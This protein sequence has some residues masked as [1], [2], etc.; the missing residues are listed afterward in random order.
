[1]KNKKILL[2]VI[3]MVAVISSFVYLAG[4][5]QAVEK[6]KSIFRPALVGTIATLDVGEKVSFVTRHYKVNVTLE[7]VTEQNRARVFYQKYDQEGNL[8]EQNL[9]VGPQDIG[10]AV[11]VLKVFNDPMGA[12]RAVIVV[13]VQ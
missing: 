10:W 5:T 1:M 6:V 13:P 4:S 9:E 11:E 3:I 7:E 8:E 2:V 12:D